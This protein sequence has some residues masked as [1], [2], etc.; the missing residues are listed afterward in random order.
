[1]ILKCIPG[2]YIESLELS[3]NWVQW[4]EFVVTVM[5]F[6]VKNKKSCTQE[7]GTYIRLRRAIYFLVLDSEYICSVHAW[8]LT[9]IMSPTSEA[10][11]MLSSFTSSFSRMSCKQSIRFYYCWSS[12][13]TCDQFPPKGREVSFRHWVQSAWGA[14]EAPLPHSPDTRS[15][16]S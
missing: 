13:K 6:R 2:K 11:N 8:L 7:L 1:M 10:M 4:R 15:A 5:N 12:C 9:R 3:H 14:H 16:L